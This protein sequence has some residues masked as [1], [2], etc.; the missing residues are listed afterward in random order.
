MNKPS[1]TTVNKHYCSPLTNI[2]WMKFRER[3]L[4]AAF[5]IL[6]SSAYNIAS[7][8]WGRAIESAFLILVDLELFEVNYYN[9]RSESACRNAR[10]SGAVYINFVHNKVP[11][12]FMTF[13]SYNSTDRLLSYPPLCNGNHF[14]PRINHYV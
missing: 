14:R 12:P 1:Y 10:R 13:P 4:E 11:L 3:A 8:P 5:A 6:V 9:I 7:S 2:L